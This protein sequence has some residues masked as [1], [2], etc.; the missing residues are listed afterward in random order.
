MTVKGFTTFLFYFFLV[1]LVVASTA[2]FFG[3]AEMGRISTLQIC[4]LFAGASLLAGRTHKGERQTEIA[5]FLLIA[6]AAMDVAL[7]VSLT[8]IVLSTNPMTFLSWAVIGLFLYTFQ[9]F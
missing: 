2:Q 1:A 3:F 4:A 5:V 9:S 8:G 7:V 6:L